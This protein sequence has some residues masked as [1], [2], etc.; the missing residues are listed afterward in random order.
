MIR[1]I[2]KW[3][4]LLA[5]VAGTAWGVWAYRKQ[6][7]VPEPKFRTAKV[8][9]ANVS[10]KVTATGT[11]SARV[12]VQ[13]G[14]QVSGRI[15]EL[16]ADFNSEV[17]KGQVIAKLDPRLFQATLA[18]ARASH[19][20]ARGTVEKA[21]ANFAQ[22]ER[23]FTRAKSLSAEGLAG[24][25]EV[26]A[27]QTAY[28]AARAD[29]TVAE[30]TL[31]QTVAALTEAQVNLGYTTIVSPIDGI[32]LSRSVDVGQTVAASLQA[33][34][35][36]TI[37]QD[38]KRIQV[39]TFVAEADI[40]KLRTGMDATFTVDAYPGQ[41]FKGTVRDI[42]NAAQ[43]V[44]N[45]VT[46]DAVL[47]VENPE[48]KLKPGMTANVTFVHAERTN[49]L[50]V[51]NAALRFRPPADLARSASPSASA[52]GGGW[53]GRRNPEEGPSNRRTIWLLEGTDPHP[54][55]V[56]TGISDGTRTEVVSGNL[57]EGDE[58]ITDVIQEGG[59]KPGGGAPPGGPMRGGGRLF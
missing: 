47:D 34:V 28:D 53:R 17:K 45:V 1:K 4:V 16:A 26:E 20:Q 25:A 24:A 13:V 3:L 15:M 56:E 22:A 32:V 31:A 6:K 46:Y 58:V 36:F 23:S 2:A 37:A 55:R 57:H 30:G 38:L 49:V 48:G 12:T 5:V 41:R 59:A 54:S 27:A 9:S 19:A 10:A 39:D 44:Q 11:L 18:R 42:R 51:P 8:E 43:T 35:L 40:G 14:S 7:Q 52:S 21:K 50:T 29:V 33:P